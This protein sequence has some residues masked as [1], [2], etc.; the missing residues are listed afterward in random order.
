MYEFW[1]NHV[2]PKYGEEAKLRYMDTD[3][4]IL[5]IKA[6]DIYEDIAR[7]AETRFY[8]SD[9]ELDRLLPKERTKK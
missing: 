4:F 6:E 3:R 2:N 5:Y 7:D 9:Y 8:T 1:H